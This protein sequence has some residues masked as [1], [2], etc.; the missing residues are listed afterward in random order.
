MRIGIL[1]DNE[2]EI[3]QMEMVI[4]EHSKISD[5]EYVYFFPFDENEV[6]KEIIKASILTS[7]IEENIDA[8]IIDESI[9]HKYWN[10]RGSEIFLEI[11]KLIPKF[12][13][14]ILTNYTEQTKENNRI[15]SDKVYFKKIFLDI[16]NNQSLE[17]VNNF[18]RNI[19]NFV[20]IKKQLENE[21]SNVIEKYINNPT[22]DNLGDILETESNLKH[23]KYI[24][25]SEVENILDKE[26][27][28]NDLNDVL[29]LID[30]VEVLLE[31][32]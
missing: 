6:T 15:D 2:L 16:S 8:I 14:I 24:N 9:V 12:P 5:I 7:I 25:H 3:V 13:S 29:K 23:Y 27:S 28:K 32:E 1:D 11:E 20:E 21:N 26:Y 17:L 4:D 22:N 30:S 31:D 10:M 18:I 19:V